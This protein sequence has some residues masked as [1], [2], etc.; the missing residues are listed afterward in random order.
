MEKMDLFSKLKIFF[1]CAFD[2][3]SCFRNFTSRLIEGNPTKQIK[4]IYRHG[5]YYT[6]EWQ[7]KKDVSL[8]I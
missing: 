1:P 7:R 3:S 6:H 8:L 5:A 2:F 4:G